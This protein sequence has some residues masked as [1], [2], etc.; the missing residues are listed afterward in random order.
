M[1]VFMLSGC[2]IFLYAGFVSM[3]LLISGPSALVFFYFIF[4]LGM[5]FFGE[6][7]IG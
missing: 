4:L 5:V 6:G 3:N 1:G 2:I 7:P